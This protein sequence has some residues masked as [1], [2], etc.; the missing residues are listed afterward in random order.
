MFP[1]LKRE[2][3]FFGE[4]IIT[5]KPCFAVAG[6]LLAAGQ[7]RRFGS[8]KQLAEIGSDVLLQR[9][10]AQFSAAQLDA[11]YLV[12]GAYAEQIQSHIALATNVIQVNNWHEGIGS[13]IATAVKYLNFNRG[14]TAPSSFS[15]VM[16]GL[17]DHINLQTGR[18]DQLLEK[19]KQAPN[20]IIASQYNE[21]FGAPCIF[22]RC[23]FDDLMALRGEYGAKKLIKRYLDSVIFLSVPEAVLDIDTQAQLACW[24]QAK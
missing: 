15:H 16:I 12:L 1:C 21:T 22:P 17:A 9:T 10:F 14:D 3:W 18:F 13:S 2:I 24:K 8:P 6:I 23:Y 11:V 5:D 4:N 19:A 7:S 20:R